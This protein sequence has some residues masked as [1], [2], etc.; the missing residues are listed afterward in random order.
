MSW[1]SD[2]SGGVHGGVGRR[3]RSTAASGVGGGVH[4]RIG[5][6]GRTARAAASMAASGAVE[7]RRGRRRLRWR[8]ALDESRAD[9]K[10]DDASLARR[11]ARGKRGGGGVA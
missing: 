5:R 3:G 2:A 8:R 1:K 11:S 6:R 10:D 4:C 9:G 7:E